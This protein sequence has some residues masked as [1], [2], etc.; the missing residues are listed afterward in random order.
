MEE[1]WKKRDKI[2]Y[3]EENEYMI[4][5][6]NRVMEAEAKFSIGYITGWKTDR[7]R[8]YIKYGTPDEIEEHLYN[9][10]TKPY[11]VWY[12]YRINKKFIFIDERRFGDYELYVY[13]KDT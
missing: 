5:Y 13:D 10:E 2:P 8:I 1:F 12:Y 7:G 6:Y 9:V 4:E 11:K 3:T